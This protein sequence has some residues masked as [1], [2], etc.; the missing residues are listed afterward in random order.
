M[1]HGSPIE[2]LA[3][4]ANP[5]TQWKGSH[6]KPPVDLLTT[7][8]LPCPRASLTSGPLIAGE[9]SGPTLG[10]QSLFLLAAAGLTACCGTYSRG[11]PAERSELH[12]STAPSCGRKDTDMQ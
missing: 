2:G 7:W 9:P 6:W 5:V 11:R 4:Q 3:S 12:R 10:S 8:V 1:F